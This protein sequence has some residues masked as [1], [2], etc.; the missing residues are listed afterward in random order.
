[1]GEPQ[2]GYRKSNILNSLLIEYKLFTVVNLKH[3]C[4]LEHRS[5][6]VFHRSKRFDPGG[7]YY[8]QTGL[9]CCYFE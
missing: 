5:K 4:G 6:R 3:D 9:C 8:R 2:V 7:A 1:M